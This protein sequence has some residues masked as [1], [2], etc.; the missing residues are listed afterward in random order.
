MRWADWGGL[1]GLYILHEVSKSTDKVTKVAMPQKEA[2]NAAIL[3]LQ[4]AYIAAITFTKEI[5]EKAQDT[6]KT[7]VMMAQAKLKSH[8]S[9]YETQVN[10]LKTGSET[11]P[12][13]G[14]QMAKLLNTIVPL[15][16]EL[17]EYLDLLQKDHHTRLIYYFE[18]EGS[19]HKLFEFLAYVK[20]RQDKWIK[21]VLGAGRN[22]TKFIGEIDPATSYFGKWFAQAE[23]MRPQVEELVDSSLTGQL[24]RYYK[25]HNSM[26]EASGKMLAASGSTRAQLIEEF[27]KSSGPTPKSLDTAILYAGQTEEEML[28]YEEDG[29]VE[30]SNLAGRM[31]QVFNKVNALAGTQID[32]A[33]NNAEATRQKAVYFLLGLGAVVMM[34]VLTLIIMVPRMISKQLNQVLEFAEIMAG[35]DFTKTLDIKSKNEMGL[36]AAAFNTMCSKLGSILKDVNQ[37]VQVVS[38]SSGE[39][40]GTAETMH[41]GADNMSTIS[42]NV[43]VAAKDMRENMDSVAAAMEQTVTNT[44]MIASA[45][46]EMNATA[47][48]IAKNAGDAKSIVDKAV[49][50]S[51]SASQNMNSLGEAATSIGKVTDLI[52]NIAEQTNLLALNATIEAARAGDAGKGFAVVAAEIKELAT[53]SADAAREI[54]ER[55][56]AI[57]GSTQGTADEIGLIAKVIEDVNGIVTTIAA[58]IEQQSA[59]TAEITKNLSESSQ[60]MNEV[61]EN[62]AQSSESVR[63]I[64]EDIAQVN[65][66]SDQMLGSSS[67]VSSSASQLSGM[68]EQLRQ[69][70]ETFKV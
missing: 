67:K 23:L 18:Y 36:L 34:I 24:S 33:Q 31:I 30:L 42:D 41:S 70:V 26:L 10:A 51:E 39:L 2:V 37:S 63:T 57:Q 59:T 45:T 40:S 64:A 46:E 53:Q 12:R 3:E 20:N 44:N 11:V 6:E 9:A 47:T 54:K 28:G 21:D 29:I 1:M 5:S 13:A 38:D 49:D 68:A 16:K 58:A 65:Q 60:G 43:A 69:Q 19:Q 61:N 17:Y 4:Q 62:V 35:G 66:A 50:R 55:I 22:N 27:E 52:Q 7:P 32:Q 25:H 48:E 14:I 56:E 15:Q 8:I